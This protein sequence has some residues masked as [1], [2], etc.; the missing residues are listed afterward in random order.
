MAISKD[1]ADYCCELL[2]GVGTPTPKRM[3]GGW[4]ISVDGVTIAVIADLGKLGGSNQKLYLKVDDVTKKQFEAA[5][6]KRFEMESK[7][8]KP[9]GMNYFTTPDETMESPDAMLPWARL[10]LH[11]ALEAK[12]KTKPKAPKAAQ[13][14]KVK[15][16]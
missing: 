16:K 3:F 1:F 7:D 6:G 5:G 14:V 8:S 4:G 13:K 12:A 10:A 11:V 15:T 9:M 2:S